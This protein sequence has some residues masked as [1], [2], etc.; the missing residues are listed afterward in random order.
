MSEDDYWDDR[1]N[2]NPTYQCED[3]GQ[4]FMTEEIVKH[5]QKGDCDE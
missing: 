1:R 4:K 2:T 3:C 5:H